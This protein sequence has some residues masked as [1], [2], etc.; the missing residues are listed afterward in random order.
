MKIQDKII[1]LISWLSG[2]PSARILP[3]T[4]IK[5][6]LSID[7]IDFALMIVE[8]EK[9]FQIEL[10]YKAIESIETVQDATVTVQR[11]TK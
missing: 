10:S 6:D 11:Y 2:V 7:S 5:D 1:H 8:I 3:S 4:H 9:F